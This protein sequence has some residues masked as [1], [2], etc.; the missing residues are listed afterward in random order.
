MLADHK[1]IEARIKT[2][3]ASSEPTQEDDPWVEYLGKVAMSDPDYI[4]MVHHIESGTEINDVDK[5]CE[6]SELHNFKDRLSVITLKG[7]QSLI[8][9]D[10]VEIL[11]PS[12]ER[13]NMLNLAHATNHRR[14]DGMVQQMRGKIWW[15][16]MNGDA[17]KINSNL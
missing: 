8:L 5:D 7:G 11:I 6:L 10:N 17:K 13:K 14:Q 3:K 9:K 2:I 4:T 15:N 12:K 16:G 1:K